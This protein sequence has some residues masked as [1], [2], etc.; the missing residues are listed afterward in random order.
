MVNTKG[1]RTCKYQDLC[2]FRD[3]REKLLNEFNAKLEGVFSEAPEWIDLKT[4]VP[5]ACC[6]NY[7]KV[8]SKHHCGHCEHCV[9]AKG[10]TKRGY[11][12]FKCELH[13]DLKPF[14]FSRAT[15]EDFKEDKA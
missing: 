10:A 11:H 8:I 1:C 13:I 2:K 3:E 12:A 5:L 4:S 9:E 7:K 6:N 14:G 15:C